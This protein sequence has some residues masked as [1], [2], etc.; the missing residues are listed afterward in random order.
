MD[1]PQ[2]PEACD[3][4]LAGTD[5]HLLLP[6]EAVPMPCDAP[7]CQARAAIPG[8][9]TRVDKKEGKVLYAADK[10]G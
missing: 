2:F 1:A 5:D 10:A 4:I 9:Q 7:V 6:P 8:A 3:E